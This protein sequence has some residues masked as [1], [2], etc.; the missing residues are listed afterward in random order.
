MMALSD[1][2][3][4]DNITLRHDGFLKLDNKRIEVWHTPGHSEDSICFLFNNI[5]I[6]GDTLFNGKI[7]RCFTGDL[8]SFFHSIKKI[9]TL[10][11]DTIIYAGHDYV[12]EYVDYIKQLEPDNIHLDYYLQNYDPDHVLSTLDDELK[13]N[14]FVRFNDNKIISILKEKG[15]NVDTEYKRWESLMSIH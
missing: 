13:I 3:F 12:E 8:E 1:A 6:S 10:P 9:L 14:P 4:I 15:L 5:I 2:D 11:K 7:G